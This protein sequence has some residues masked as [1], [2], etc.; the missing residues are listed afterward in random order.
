[1]KKLSRRE[2]EK[3]VREAEIVCA[4][5]KLFYKNG[6]TS[7]SMDQIAAAAE[8]TK[9]TLYQYFTGKEDLYLAVA[10]KGFQTLFNYCNR[11]IEKG[12][13]GFEKIKLAFMAYFQFYND[14]PEAFRL[15]NYVGEVKKEDSPVYKKFLSFDENMFHELASIFEQGKQDGSMRSDI[16]SKK[17]AYAIAFILTGFFHELSLAG[18]TFTG[19]LELN[20]EEFCRFA[21]ELLSHALRPYSS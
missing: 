12:K 19:H 5:E 7:V 3:Q 18:K 8:F 17:T 15:M 14:F 6:F 11:A 21:L 10:L 20:Q 13:N 2:K 1:M 4:A 16:D 9:R